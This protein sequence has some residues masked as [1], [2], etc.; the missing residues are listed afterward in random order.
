MKKILLLLCLLTCTVV[1]MAQQQVRGK[2][3]SAK[4]KMPLPGAAVVLKGT[5]TGVTTGTEGEFTL[6]LV[7]EQRVLLVSFLGYHTRELELTYPLPDVLEITLQ[8]NENTL[9]EVVVS[10]GYQQVPQER[11]TGSFAQV[12]QERFNEQVS[13]DVLSRLEGVA[14]GLT[15]DRG[16]LEGGGILVRGLSTIQGPKAPLIVVDNFPYEGDIRNINPNDV[17]SITVLKDA[18]AASIWGSR[19]GNGVIVI[20]TKQGRFNQP[21][22]VEFNTNI[23]V[24][25]KPDLSYIDQMSSSDYIEVEQLLFEKGYYNN[26]ITSPSMPPL[27]PVVELLVQKE[28]GTITA[29]QADAQLAA[30]RQ[31]DVRDAYNQHLYGRGVNQQYSLGLR[32]G[33]ATNAWLLSAGYDQNR[34]NLAASFQRLNVRF[35]NTLRPVNNLEIFTG[36]NYTRSEGRSGK[37]AYGEGNSATARLYPYT[38]F[39]DAQG[40]P[41]PVTRDYRQP[42]KQA[43]GDGRLLDWNY[44]PLEDYRHDRTGSDLQEVLGNLALSYRLPFGLEA[45]VR[46]QYQRQ[47]A[48]SQ[49]LQ[50]A[51]S[52]A[53]RNLVNTF[54]FLDTAT[55]AIT[56]GIPP[57]AILDQ[58][59]EG[60]EVHN[61]RGQLNFNRAW[62]HHEVAALAG[63]EV[64]HGRTTGRSR[65]IYGYN[66]DILTYGQ[67]DYI[68]MHP[69]FVDGSP[70]FIPNRDGL[71]D[72]LNRFVSV[73][74]NGSYT[75]KGRYMLSGSAR[76]DASNLF[77]VASND[78]W[79][80]LWSAGMGWDISAEPFYKAAFLPYLKLR[81]SF[82][83][84]GNTD[85]SRTAVTTMLYISLS[86]YTQSPYAAFDQY[87]NR[88]L[89]W[90][91][92]R[93]LNVG[94]DFR[95][96]HDRLTGT[97]EYYRKKGTDLFGRE[98][99]ESTAGIGSSIIKN[100]ASMQGAGVDLELSSI[101][102]QAAAFRWT[103]HLNASYAKDEVTEY[104]LSNL[105]GS[106]FV[107]SVPT[108]SA[109]PGKPVYAI[110]SYRWAG[111][112]PL[113]GD[114]QGYVSGE[115]SKD[116]QALTGPTTQVADLEYHGSA[117]PTLFGSLGN[118]LTYKGFSL[119]A[120]LSY[121][122]GY[123]FRRPSINYGNLFA[124][125]LGS[126]DYARRWQQ[127]GDEATTEVP[128]LLYPDDFRR[129]A[130]YS[131]SAAL[132]ERGDHVRLQYLTAAYELTKATW[133]QLPFQK[134]QA[135]VSVS[136]LGLL[137]TANNKGIDPDYN[138]NSYA[139]PPARNYTVGIRA[140]F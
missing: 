84:S 121:K 45:A 79:N 93:M 83:F 33:S 40:N 46:Y 31:L 19:A 20:T 115:V 56:Y 78:R 35:Q 23:T 27:S 14:N 59:D 96:K 90:E 99:L 28:N 120:R 64:R 60:L 22:S 49:H 18:A 127:P 37:S 21:F 116:Y 71:S 105:N 57:G 11:A 61:A 6:P 52:Y 106:A 124:L 139:V 128:S 86:P 102:L 85:L 53:A 17:Q 9:Q 77:G 98:L 135:Y 69:V 138:L 94:V 36:L 5:N 72:R 126:G 134:I 123:F 29:E 131:G 129:D 2:V 103:S 140:A 68:N 137:W 117:L 91:T 65:R 81:A 80:P 55:G 15:V 110:Y 58:G 12:S 136:N 42:Y 73:F 44:Y 54:T 92:A 10:T 108:I 7:S 32:G 43:A 87:A 66:D 122:L 130:F 118:T 104:Y 125:G 89:R 30:W 112:D 107:G 1:G 113:T 109:V 41:L 48:S 88:D 75:Y 16:T 3:L 63:G 82:G 39:A 38:R 119:T 8:E 114:P 51:Q 70:A 25:N 47:Q 4:D 95:L 62:G 133:Q 24:I 132:V 74:G 101:N 13:T 34:D 67:V 50:D 97:L 111:L 100:A 26:D 76:Q